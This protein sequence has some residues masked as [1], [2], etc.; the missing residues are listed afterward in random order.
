MFKAI[1][2]KTVQVLSLLWARSLGKKQ[3]GDIKVKE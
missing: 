2:V 1:L 3:T